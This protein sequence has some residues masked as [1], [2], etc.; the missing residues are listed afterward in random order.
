MERA[1]VPGYAAVTMGDQ[2]AKRIILARRARFVAAALA[3]LNAAMCGGKSDSGTPQP[4]LDFAEDGGNPR[5]CLT[6]QQQEDAGR[7][8]DAEP[9]PCLAPQPEDAGDGGDGG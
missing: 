5:P 2:E 7:D 3:G 1:A 6:P 4:C 8:A 9:Q